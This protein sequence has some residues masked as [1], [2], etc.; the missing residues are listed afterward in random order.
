MVLPLISVHCLPFSCIS[1]PL[2]LCF[3]GCLHVHFN[4]A[5]AKAI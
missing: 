5:I 1:A 2:L 3:H 4:D